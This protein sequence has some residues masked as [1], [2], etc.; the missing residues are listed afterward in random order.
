MGRFRSR[1]VELVSYSKFLVRD[2]QSREVKKNLIF[3][4]KICFLMEE[5]PITTAK[6]ATNMIIFVLNVNRMFWII[7]KVVDNREM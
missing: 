5:S 1:K 4:G 6:V 7:L 3:R 2:Y